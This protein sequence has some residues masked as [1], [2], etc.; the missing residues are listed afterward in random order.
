M[1]VDEQIAE[2]AESGGRFPKAAYHFV[3]QGVAASVARRNYT[4]M[5]HVSA[6]ELL[7]MLTHLMREQYGPYVWGVLSTWNIACGADFG[8]IVFELSEVGLLAIS[9]ND[10]PES[11]EA[12][13]LRS[14]LGAESRIYNYKEMPVIKDWRD[15]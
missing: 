12:F 14:A 1:T 10:S 9:E 2:L 8:K 13:D 3:L 11:F 4:R 6:Q 5:E 7:E 15:F